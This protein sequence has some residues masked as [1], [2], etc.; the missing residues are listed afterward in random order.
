MIRGLWKGGDTFYAQ[1][2]LP[3]LTSAKSEAA[4]FEAT[5]VAAACDMEL[6]AWSSSVTTNKLR[7]G[8]PRFDA[9]AQEYSRSARLGQKDAQDPAI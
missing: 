5:L 1:L 6:D 7:D 4:W 3:T 9:Y 2:F 8:P